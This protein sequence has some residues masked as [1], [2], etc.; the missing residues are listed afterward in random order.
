MLSKASKE[1]LIKAVCQ[2][3]P[4]YT[5]SVFRLPLSS[6]NEIESIFARYWWANN[7]G[8][9]I[10]WKTWKHLCKIKSVGGLGFQEISCFNQALLGKQGWRLLEFPNSLIAKMS[11]LGIVA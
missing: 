2:A 1:V 5:M 3:I 9:G 11:K 8:R 4:S 7:N 10:H 6:C